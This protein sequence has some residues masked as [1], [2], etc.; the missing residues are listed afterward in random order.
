LHRAQCQRPALA[1]PA[2][3]ETIDET[4]ATI[5]DAGG[6]AIAIRVDHSVES[7]VKAL[8]SRIARAHK[9]D[10]MADSVAGE[11]PLTKR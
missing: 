8:F 7:E 5:N 11:L 10:I 3:P 2:R 1:L 9:R 4:A 6:Q